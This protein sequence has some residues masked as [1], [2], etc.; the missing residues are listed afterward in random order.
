MSSTDT[1]NAESDREHV[2][3]EQSD[4]DFSTHSTN[5]LLI[6]AIVPIHSQPLRFP[7]KKRPLA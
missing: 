4:S 1:S 5:S 2:L 6:E 3:W 7:L